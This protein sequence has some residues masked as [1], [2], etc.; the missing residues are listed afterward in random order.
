MCSKAVN[1][2]SFKK[3][4]CKFVKN[5]LQLHIILFVGKIIKV[6]QCNQALSKSDRQVNSKQFVVNN[7]LGKWY[8]DT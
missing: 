8:K 5:Y 2:I 6:H 7:I 4:L 3:I 1:Y